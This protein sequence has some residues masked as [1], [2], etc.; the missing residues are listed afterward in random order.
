VTHT[1]EQGLDEDPGGCVS[2]SWVKRSPPTSLSPAEVGKAWHAALSQLPAEEDDFIW[3]EVDFSQPGTFQVKELRW[4]IPYK[5]RRCTEMPPREPGPLVLHFYDRL[6]S[7]L[8]ESTL[9]LKFLGTCDEQYTPC[10]QAFQSDL[11]KRPELPR[12]A[13]AKLE[14]DCYAFQQKARGKTPQ[15]VR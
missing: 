12:I 2:V 10:A 6:P 1:V 3:A 15:P 11:K 9:D 5:G 13:Y 4:N 14:F 7:S 8:E